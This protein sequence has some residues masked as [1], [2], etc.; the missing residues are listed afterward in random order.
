MERLD[1]SK[2]KRVGGMAKVVPKVRAAHGRLPLF[3]SVGHHPVRYLLGHAEVSPGAALR[4]IRAGRTITFDVW[5]V[6]EAAVEPAAGPEGV[7]AVR[8]P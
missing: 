1:W 5:E 6:Q 4:H 2:M 8:E 3:S 7:A